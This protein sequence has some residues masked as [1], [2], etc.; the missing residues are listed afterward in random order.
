MGLT[1][2]WC[3]FITARVVREHKR[4]TKL[5][6]DSF[7]THTIIFYHYAQRFALEKDFLGNHEEV[8]CPK[9]WFSIREDRSWYYNIDERRRK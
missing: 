9:N 7:T 1:L 3:Y 8:D 5:M 2:A 6:E 4:T